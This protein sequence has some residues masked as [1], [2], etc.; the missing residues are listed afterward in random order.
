MVTSKENKAKAVK[1]QKLPSWFTICEEQSRA[2]NSG[3]FTPRHYPVMS[4]S[5]SNPQGK[6]PN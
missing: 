5:S 3:T 6:I 2:A 4:L 1:V